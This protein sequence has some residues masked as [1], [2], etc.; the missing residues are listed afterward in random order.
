MKINIH[1][2]KPFT[3][4]PYLCLEWIN[5]I[6]ESES[7]YFSLMV[8]VRKKNSEIR[9]CVDYRKFISLAIKENQPLPRI[10]N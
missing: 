6:R 4:R 3:Y 8:L 2:G 1:E 5:N 7:E 9:L 10:D